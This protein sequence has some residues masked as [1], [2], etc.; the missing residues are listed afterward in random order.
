MFF[1]LIIYANQ[2]NN[3]AT[4][5]ILQKNSCEFSVVLLLFA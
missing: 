4:K 5:I 3:N 1:I 2:S